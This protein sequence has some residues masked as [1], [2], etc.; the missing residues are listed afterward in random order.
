MRGVKIFFYCASGPATASR[1]RPIDRRQGEWA[2]VGDFL[3]WLSGVS[4]EVLAQCRSERPKFIGLGA[5]ILVTAGMAAVS[6]SFALV[7]A[8]KAPLWAALIFAL[9]WGLAIMSLDRLFVVSM[10]RYRNPLYYLVMAV[11]RLVMA[12][13]LGFVISTPFVLQIFKPEINHQIKLMQAAERSAYFEDLPHNP[14][15]LTVQQDKATVASLTDE[16]ATGGAAINPSTDPTIIGWQK[17]LASAQANEQNWFANLQC[18]LYG[19]ALPGGRK[20]I[21]GNGP[22]AKDDQGQYEY[23]KGQVSTLQQEI[24]QRTATLQ[25]Q[26]A[27]QQKANQGQAAAQLSAAKQGLQS[28]QQQLNLQTSNVTSGIYTDTGILTQLKALSNAT[29][30][31]STLAW[32]RL[33]LFLVFLI[34][35][36]MPVFIKLLLNLAPESTYDSILAEEER[37]QKRIAEHTRAVR[38]AAERKAALAEISGARDRLAALSAEVPGMRDQ[39]MSVRQRVEQEWLKRWETDQMHRVAN[40]QGITPA[41][42]GVGPM[43]P[44]DSWPRYRSDGYRPWPPRSGRASQ[45]GRARPPRQP[46]PRRPRQPDA[47][48]PRQDV[49]RRPAGEAQLWGW[50]GTLFSGLKRLALGI[51]RDQRAPRP[52]PARP[53]RRASGPEAQPPPQPPW[54]GNATG[55]GPEPGAGGQVRILPPTEPDAPGLRMTAPAEADAGSAYDASANGWGSA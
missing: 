8:L 45:N 22:L 6:L 29:A 42:T 41:D 9:L 25:G 38:Q 50:A 36:I 40:G 53:P 48:R 12:V 31:N 15:Y 39:I 16:A 30:G 17:Q 4:R 37:Q 1:G 44:P 11:P 46:G 23:W 32:A 24:Q 33:L 20:C 3:I 13:L 54:R 5:V 28:A 19:T 10:H 34:I 47:Q 26:S 35:D 49:R 18:Q 43:P 2:G 51:G 55:P 52:E 27:A 21:Q 7:N 14:V